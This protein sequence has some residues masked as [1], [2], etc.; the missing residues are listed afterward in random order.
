MKATIFA[1]ALSAAFLTAASYL[2]TAS[3]HD[4][5]AIDARSFGAGGTLPQDFR[6]C[7]PTSYGYSCKT[8]EKAERDAAEARKRQANAA[9]KPKARK[10]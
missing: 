6:N 8:Q 7:G 1:A 2:G 3:A 9:K 4:P 5:F 10:R